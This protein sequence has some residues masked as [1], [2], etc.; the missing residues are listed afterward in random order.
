MTLDHGHLEF[1]QRESST[2][3]C[4]AYVYG[5]YTAMF[6]RLLGET[7]NPSISALSTQFAH[8]QATHDN[9]SG[10]IAQIPTGGL[11]EHEQYIL[12]REYTNA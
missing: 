3:N 5:R 4:I 1:S 2:V 12:I 9:R 11:N 8:G 6:F 10:V 7:V